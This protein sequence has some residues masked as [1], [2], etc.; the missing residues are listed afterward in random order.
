M[1][2]I[3]LQCAIV[4]K[5]TPMLNAMALSTAELSGGLRALGHSATCLLGVTAPSV[6]RRA[7]ADIST[8]LLEVM[9]CCVLGVCAAPPF[10]HASKGQ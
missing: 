7:S 4:T 8:A 10:R 6:G 5:D 3:N 2:F 1:L 9:Y